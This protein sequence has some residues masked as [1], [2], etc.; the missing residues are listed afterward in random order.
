MRRVFSAVVL[1]AVCGAMFVP[2]AG[3][4]QG[5]ETVKVGVNKVI[6]DIVF[7][8]AEERGFFS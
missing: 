7:Y 2:D 8:I 1:I 4:A 3:R 6:S 5:M